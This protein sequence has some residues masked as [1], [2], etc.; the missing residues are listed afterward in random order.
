MFCEL[1]S[2]TYCDNQVNRKEEKALL[3]DLVD[4]IKAVN[5]LKFKLNSF[6]QSN[7]EY[8]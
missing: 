8:A 2:A 7:P 4:K 1:C 5:N 6:C 3:F